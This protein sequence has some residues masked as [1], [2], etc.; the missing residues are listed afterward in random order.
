MTGYYSIEA[1][2][3]KESYIYLALLAPIE[4]F[5]EEKNLIPFFFRTINFP[6]PKAVT[7]YG[8]Y[9][10]LQESTC[11]FIPKESEGGNFVK[12]RAQGTPA[13]IKRDFIPLYSVE[14]SYAKEQFEKILLFIK[15]NT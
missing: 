6:F 3:E 12:L 9:F 5:D 1:I 11:Y 7:T 8:I 13:Q 2:N 4:E 15:K 10:C 14:T